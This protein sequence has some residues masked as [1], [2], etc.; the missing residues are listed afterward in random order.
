MGNRIPR[1]LD[2]EEKFFEKQI[3]DEETVN[4]LITKGNER[5]GLISLTPEGHSAEK[6]AQVGIWLYPE[7][8]R[9]GY[10]TEAVRLITDYGFKQLNYHKVYARAHQGNKASQSIWEKLGFEKEGEF[11][12]HTFTQGEYKDVVYYGVLE[13]EW[14]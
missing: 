12:D 2:N 1:N 3:C 6:I 13:G 10:G 14:Q 11:R 8:H 5:L 7:H 4:L 9:N